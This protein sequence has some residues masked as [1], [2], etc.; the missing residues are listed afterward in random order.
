MTEGHCGVQLSGMRASCVALAPHVG[1]AAADRLLACPHPTPPFTVLP[2]PINTAACP[3]QHPEKPSVPQPRVRPRPCQHACMLLCCS[4]AHWAHT[5]WQH[6]LC[7]WQH[8]APAKPW[9]PSQ[10]NQN[11]NA[12]LCRKS[13]ATDYEHF[14]IGQPAS[15]TLEIRLNHLGDRRQINVSYIHVICKS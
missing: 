4:G 15:T 3:P 12:Y 14:C 9:W 13:I 5:A 10:S 7:A 8:A 2:A 11:V 6:A 1:L